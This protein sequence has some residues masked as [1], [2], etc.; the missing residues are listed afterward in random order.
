[1]GI[2]L[3]ELDVRRF[4]EMLDKDRMS[5]RKR[6]YASRLASEIERAEILPPEQM[7]ADVVTM[8]S[9]VRVRD[10]ATGTTQTFHLVYP[11]EADPDLLKVSILD[12]L[13]LAVIGEKVGATVS[14]ESPRG[15]K[16]IVIEK[17]HY[18]PE[19]LKKYYL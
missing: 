18:Q 8:R 11:D 16:S 15:M 19:S 10:T 12:P 4:R 5:R 6:E 1:M 9:L 2:T 7:P 14:W 13:G 17:M 3:N